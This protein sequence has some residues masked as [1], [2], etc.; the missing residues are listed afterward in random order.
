MA[1]THLQKGADIPVNSPVRRNGLYLLLPGAR[2]D[3]A[4]VAT[5]VPTF[6]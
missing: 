2:S 3:C 1:M 5:P 6:E 4:E